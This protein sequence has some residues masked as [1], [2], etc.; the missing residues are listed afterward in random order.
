MGSL[1]RHPPQPRL[2]TPHATQTQPHDRPAGFC[3]PSQSRTTLACAAAVFWAV[4]L[5]ACSFP[6]DAEPI[7]TASEV[8]MTLLGVTLSSPIDMPQPVNPVITLAFSDIVDPDTGSLVALRLGGKGSPLENLIEHN[9]VERK[10]ILRP[11]ASLVPNTE[12]QIDVSTSIK[13]L[14]G[15]AID[16]NSRVTFRTG[17]AVLPTTTEPPLVLADIIGD[18]G[19]LKR[20]CTATGCHSAQSPGEIAARGLDLSQATPTLRSYLT[21]AN[22]SGSPEALRLV[23]PGQPERSYLLRKLLAGG[24]FTRIVGDPMPGEGSPLLETSALLAVQ[25]WIRQGAN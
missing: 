10:L 21:S 23:Q 14:A 22:A 18:K 4:S 24:S 25:S 19:Q 15:V 11:K 13:S 1:L 2:H 3:A 9:L 6:T 8:P 17:T 16:K 7:P 5:G 12:Y 20:S